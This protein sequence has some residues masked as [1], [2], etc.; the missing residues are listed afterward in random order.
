ME[1]ASL[2]KVRQQDF[3]KTCKRSC[4]SKKKFSANSII[5]PNHKLA[6]HHRT[7]NCHSLPHQFTHQPCVLHS[8]LNEDYI[9]IIATISTNLYSFPSSSSPTEHTVSFEISINNYDFFSIPNQISCSDSINSDDDCSSIPNSENFD[10]TKYIFPIKHLCRST[11]HFK[12]KGSKSK[13]NQQ[14]SLTS[15]FSD[16]F[17]TG[18]ESTNSPVPT[19]ISNPPD[20]NASNTSSSQDPPIHLNQASTKHSNSLIPN[21]ADTDYSFFFIPTP[22][23]I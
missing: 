2:K 22:K 16:S 18:R 23:T 5:L 17:G 3:R 12:L 21:Q 8:I 14:S 10:I 11:W 20:T 15:N 13:I 7:Y 4:K 9:S 19:T 6:T 1:L